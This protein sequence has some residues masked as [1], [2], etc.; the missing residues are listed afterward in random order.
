MTY[1]NQKV[2]H[3]RQNNIAS[4]EILAWSSVANFE[5]VINRDVKAKLNDAVEIMPNKISTGFESFYVLA[6]LKVG[7]LMLTR[8][9][10]SC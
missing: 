6:A 1:L 4:T 5:E 7:L 9:N 10:R 8:Q 2:S 3:L